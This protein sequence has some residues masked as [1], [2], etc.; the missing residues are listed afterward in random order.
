MRAPYTGHLLGGPSEV[1]CG[2]E[3][4]LEYAVLGDTAMIGTLS[5]PLFNIAIEN[6][7]QVGQ[8]SFELW[9]SIENNSQ[10]DVAFSSRYVTLFYHYGNWVSGLPLEASAT[11]PTELAAGQAL[12]CCF[13]RG[14]SLPIAKAGHSGWMH[15]E[16]KLR[17]LEAYTGFNDLMKDSGLEIEAGFFF[18][19]PCGNGSIH[20]Q[21]GPDSEG[22]FEQNPKRV[23]SVSSSLNNFLRVPSTAQSVERYDLTKRAP[24]KRSVVSNDSAS[25][26]Q[27]SPWT[28]KLMERLRLFLSV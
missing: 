14:N 26:C 27:K 22:R 19:V 15:G 12:R 11:L 8:E 13:H 25:N 10:H 9:L 28:R 20:R 18:E 3:A 4:D 1:Y 16:K 17:G 24:Q 6:K 23:L 21:K 7:G 5:E 2:K